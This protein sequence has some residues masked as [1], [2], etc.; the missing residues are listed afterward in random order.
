MKRYIKHTL[1]G[2][3]LGIVVILT[4]CTA[5]EIEDA[6]IT[7]PFRPGS[8]IDFARLQDVSVINPTDPIYVVVILK[9]APND[10]QFRAE[11][12]RADDPNQTAI[13]R[14]EIEAGSGS[15][16]FSMTPT[17]FWQPGSHE[18]VLYLND[19]EQRILRFEVTNKPFSG[20]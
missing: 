16:E 10:T 2:L 4:G 3:M 9:N 6:R 12:R 5:P 15:V 17:T 8:E 18:V 14:V 19:E 1:W 13:E 7:S 11:L 20:G